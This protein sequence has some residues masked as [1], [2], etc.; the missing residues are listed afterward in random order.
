M[1]GAAA[2]AGQHVCLQLKWEVCLPPLLWNF[3]PSATLTSFPTPGC[4]A[5]IPA[6]AGAS[7]A[8]P[9][10][11]IYNSRRNSLNPPL[12][13]SACHPLSHVSLLFLLLITQFLFLPW[14]E[15]G[16]SRGLC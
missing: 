15:V 4:W 2:P 1:G 14:V 5:H 8:Q 16:L 7:L 12:V 9:G 11:F 10:L 6:P 3:P 13:L